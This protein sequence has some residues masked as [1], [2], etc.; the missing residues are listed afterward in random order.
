MYESMSDVEQLESQKGS[1]WL[2][3]EEICLSSISLVRKIG[4]CD[5]TTRSGTPSMQILAIL[6]VLSC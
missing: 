3:W 6:E 1:F 4:N 5:N 2:I